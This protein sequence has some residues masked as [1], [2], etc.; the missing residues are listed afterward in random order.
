MRESLTDIL[1]SFLRMDKRESRAPVFKAACSAFRELMLSGLEFGFPPG[2]PLWAT[3]AEA[4]DC[5]FS[6]AGRVNVGELFKESANFSEEQPL[7][8][9]SLARIAD[10]I[11]S[12]AAVPNNAAQ[13]SLVVTSGRLLRYMKKHQ[14]KA[15]SALEKVLP[16]PAAD[17][18]DLNRE[19]D[20]RGAGYK[21]L[22]QISTAL[23]KAA[24]APG[25]KKKVSGAAAADGGGQP[26]AAP[27]Q[28]SL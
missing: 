26:L 19:A 13:F 21:L 6:G 23:H 2:V 25:H 22:Q 14:L 24:A 28:G 12:T 4:L 5:M 15:Y 27:C 18:M 1:V 9:S 7:G 20:F 17:I 11:A 8:T 3:T 10:L 16:I